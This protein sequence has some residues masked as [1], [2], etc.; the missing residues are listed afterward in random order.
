M[1]FSHR[2]YLTRIDQ[3]IT[4]AEQMDLPFWFLLQHK[5]EVE[6]SMPA[7]SENQVIV[8]ET[9]NVRYWKKNGQIIHYETIR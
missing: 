2:Y 1:K 5:K 3:M 6:K 4:M 7:I 9:E 8:E